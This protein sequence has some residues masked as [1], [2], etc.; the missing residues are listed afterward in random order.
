M[1]KAGKI[2]GF[3]PEDKGTYHT[4]KELDSFKHMH[5]FAWSDC[6]A[7]KKRQWNIK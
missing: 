2:E 1:I 6:I 5:P 7:E 3:F 4:M